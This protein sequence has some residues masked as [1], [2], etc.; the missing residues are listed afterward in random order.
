MKWL[1]I[2]TRLWPGWFSEVKNV[3]NQ[4]EWPFKCSEDRGMDS[5]HGLYHQYVFKKRLLLPV[6]WRQTC[7]WVL[8]WIWTARAT[9]PFFL[10]AMRGCVI[11][12]IAVDYTCF[13]AFSFG[14]VLNFLPKCS[15][16]IDVCTWEV[17]TL[18][19]EYLFGR[20]QRKWTR[21]H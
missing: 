21:V 12:S 20:D 9:L 15:I 16:Y 3:T 8:I 13:C 1:N 10:Q 5:L 2:L 17:D 14:H 7:C 19:N 4:P 11:Y 6:R 18:K